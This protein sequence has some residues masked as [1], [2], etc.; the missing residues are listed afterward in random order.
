MLTE[1]TKEVLGLF[2]FSTASTS[3]HEA[4]AEEGVWHTACSR[5]NKNTRSDSNF[6]VQP[7]GRTTAQASVSNQVYQIQHSVHA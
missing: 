1:S 7:I 3:S 6:V 4:S 2:L 5:C